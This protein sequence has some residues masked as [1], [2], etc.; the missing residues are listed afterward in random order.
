MGG[1]ASRALHAGRLL[2][3][4]AAVRSDT[5]ADERVDQSRLR[6]ARARRAGRG[7]RRCVP[8]EL[9]RG[10]NCHRRSRVLSDLRSGSR[11]DRARRHLLSRVAELRRSVARP[12]GHVS[13][14]ELHAALQPLP[15][16]PSGTGVVRP[17][18][19]DRESRER[20]AA[21]RLARGGAPW[22]RGDPA[23][24]IRRR[25]GGSQGISLDRR[26]A[27]P[28][29]GSRELRRRVRDLDARPA[30]GWSARRRAGSRDTGSGT[31]S[32]PPPRGW[33][34]CTFG[35]SVRARGGTSRA[36]EGTHRACRGGPSARRP[37]CSRPSRCG[38]G[39][40][41]RRAAGRPPSSA[42]RARAA[43]GT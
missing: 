7:P 3:R 42:C 40:R 2:L 31:C 37:R 34:I 32:P 11:R 20:H 39:A 36:P 21:R 38:S 5:P 17:R 8:R 26:H 16:R 43:W 10:E 29:R 4:E 23:G 25:R 24:G 41:G 15:T 12:H 18:V 13:A 1:L 6:A 9:R 19:R 14:R 33:S 30:A 28:L 27:A 22:V 35:R